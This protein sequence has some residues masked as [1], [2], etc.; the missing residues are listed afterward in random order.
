MAD[1]IALT[2]GSK[3]D[4]I[5]I[6]GSVT[7]GFADLAGFDED[8]ANW[9]ELAIREAVIN[10]VKHGNRHATELPVDI[11]YTL[12]RGT[13]IIDVRDRG[14]GFDPSTVPDPLD[15]KNLLSP[16]GR[17]IFYMKSFMDDVAF[18]V[19]PDGGTIVRMTKC[20]TES[21]GTGK[22]ET[23]SDGPSDD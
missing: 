7:K 19:H 2:I 17:G 10:A 11:V 14:A 6:V 5:E 16:N 18:S 13:L 20:R 1:S 4:F 8:A 12:D 21:D 23:R 15:P 22:G 3:F 9:I